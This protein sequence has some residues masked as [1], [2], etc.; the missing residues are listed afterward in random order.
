MVYISAAEHVVIQH[1]QL[2]TWSI[3]DIFLK[4]PALGL[5]CRS[6]AKQCSSVPFHIHWL[7][8]CFHVIV[9]N[10][11]KPIKPA[12][13]KSPFFNS[14]FSPKEQRNL[15]QPGP[16]AAAASAGTAGL[17]CFARSSAHDVKK[18]G[19][20]KGKVTKLMFILLHALS[21]MRNL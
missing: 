6:Q 21:Q 10:R 13:S 1:H 17:R 9:T 14:E 18:I 16:K 11:Y 4:E 20:F 12:H 2:A 7:T 19:G 8:L 5:W 15:S 3:S